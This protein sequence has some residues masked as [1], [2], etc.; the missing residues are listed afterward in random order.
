MRKVIALE[1]DSRL[2]Y[3]VVATGGFDSERSSPAAAKC[4]QGLESSGRKK[5]GKIHEETTFFQATEEGEKG[6]RKW[7]FSVV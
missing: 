7:T 1:T 5:G 2:S 6:G 3:A 4:Q